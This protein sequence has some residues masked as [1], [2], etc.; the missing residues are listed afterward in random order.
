MNKSLNETGG[1]IVI[2]AMTSIS[3]I[4]MLVLIPI[5]GINQGAQPIIG[6]NYGAKN[7]EYS[8][9]NRLLAMEFA[10]VILVIGFCNIQLL[11]ATFVKMFDGNGTMLEIATLLSL[12]RQVVILI[13]VIYITSRIGGLKGVWLA[14]SVSDI[15]STVIVGIILIK[16]FKSYKAI[17][18]HSATSKNL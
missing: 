9:K 13:L 17:G 5:F 16:E 10:T 3:A 11:P 8:K 18:Q 2:G 7:Y 15:I 4:V 14:Q 6:Y 12:L 1:Q